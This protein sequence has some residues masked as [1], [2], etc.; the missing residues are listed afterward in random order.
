MLPQLV[1]LTCYGLNSCIYYC[2]HHIRGTVPF[3][4]NSFPVMTDSKKKICFHRIIVRHNKE[5]DSFLSDKIPRK[6][7]N[8]VVTEIR[9]KIG[10]GL[11]V[12]N[13][14]VSSCVSSL[15]SRENVRTRA[16]TVVLLYR[17]SC[18]E[19][20]NYVTYMTRLV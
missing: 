13:T 4:A 19:V 12:D 17:V 2:I 3:H 10:C 15:R 20:E 9:K 18:P 14:V 7:S 16:S 11:M 1:G 8:G 5:G 6:V